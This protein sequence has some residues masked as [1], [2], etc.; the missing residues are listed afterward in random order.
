[1]KP[2][3]P[4]IRIVSGK[5]QLRTASILAVDELEKAAGLAAGRL[6]LVQKCEFVIIE[7][8]EELLPG[9]SLK[10][11]ILL[12]E[13]ETQDTTLALAGAHDSGT[14]V[15]LFGPG[16]DLVVVRRRAR[17]AQP[18]LLKLGG[19]ANVGSSSLFLNLRRE[20][21][22]VT[23][24]GHDIHV[25]RLPSEDVPSPVAWGRTLARA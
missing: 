21:G 6:V 2:A 5:G 17:A 7:N 20:Q 9:Y 13:I 25:S 3:P 4:V 16:P 1:M 11:L 15:P 18:F 24:D 14:P 22:A 23:P 12:A 19:K 8:L 10:F